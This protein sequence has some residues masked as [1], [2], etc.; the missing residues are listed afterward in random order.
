MSHAEAVGEEKG[1]KYGTK[2]LQCVVVTP[3]KTWLDELV[4]SVVCRFMTV[5]WGSC[6]ATRR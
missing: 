1:S 6:P 5:N 2:R 3:E 4:D